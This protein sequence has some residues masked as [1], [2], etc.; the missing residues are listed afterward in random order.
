M[1]SRTIKLFAMMVSLLAMVVVAG[2]SSSSSEPDPVTPPVPT[3]SKFVGKWWLPMVEDPTLGFDATIADNGAFVLYKHLSTSPAIAGT[4]VE[5]ATKEFHGEGKQTNGSMT[6]TCL[7][8]LVDDNHMNF[9]F[10]E[11]KVTGDKV[12]AH[13]GTR[14]P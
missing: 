11:H 5:T 13:T 6:V 1:K 2:C 3:V 7:G 14:V 10:I 4:W 9:T 8:T 12:V